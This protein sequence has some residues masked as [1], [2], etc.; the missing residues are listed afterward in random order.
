MKYFCNKDNHS[1]FG[2]FGRG[3]E[4]ESSCFQTGGVDIDLAELLEIDQTK[5]FNTF[6]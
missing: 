3:V 4:P 5:Q 2:H 6:F 1:V